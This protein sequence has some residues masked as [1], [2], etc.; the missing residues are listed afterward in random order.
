MVSRV[1]RSCVV[2]AVALATTM[3][4]AGCAASGPSGSRSSASSAA[5]PAAS[6]GALAAGCDQAAWRSAPVSVTHT[7]AVPPVSTVSA[8]RTAQH[9][10]CGYDRLVLDITGQM[11]S[12]GISYVG[13]VTAA[14]SGK[15]ISLPGQ[16]Y[17][18]ITL[19]SAQAHSA[20]GAATISRAIQ[21]PGYPALKSWTVTGDFEGVVTIAVGLPGQVSLRT[22]ELPGHLYID[23]KE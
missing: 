12:Y 2:S 17:L 15:A 4:G 1:R 10:E 7:T 3:L 13:Q 14:S 16:R 20:S 19:H 21:Q 23:F 22:G 9:P 8:V 5:P 11:P 18:L 6:A